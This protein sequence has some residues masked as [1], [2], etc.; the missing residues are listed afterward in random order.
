MQSI[1]H[2]RQRLGCSAGVVVRHPSSRPAAVTHAWKD[3]KFRHVIDSREFSRECLNI[4][5]DIA[6]RMETVKPG[7]PESKMLEG[8]TM[9]TLFYEPSTRT[10][11]SFEA[12]MGKLGG[13]ILSTESAGQFSS[14]AKGETL[15][16][17][18]T[19]IYKQLSVPLCHMYR[20]PLSCVQIQLGLW[21]DTQTASCYVT[22][23]LVQQQLLL[24]FQ[25]SQS[26][27]QAMGLVSIP[28]RYMS[29]ILVW[30]V[31]EIFLVHCEAA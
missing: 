15:E 11:L 29:R 3:S 30:D 6:E 8:Y 28:L 22:S 4:V 16:G 9:A 31:L 24:L 26:S 19:C 14:A 17:T 10:R 18:P 12:A 13:V 20:T 1:T 27:A 21:K 25:A 2:K 23:M 5:F 7:T